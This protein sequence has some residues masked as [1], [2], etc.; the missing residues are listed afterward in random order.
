MESSEK[1]DNEWGKLEH[2][3]NDDK[4]SFGM[5]RGCPVLQL[6]PLNGEV[7]S[8][9]RK[10]GQDGAARFNPFVIGNSSGGSV[11]VR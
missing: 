2:T 3:Q 5:G 6:L 7:T 11:A 1:S 10:A 8:T 9:S 4:L